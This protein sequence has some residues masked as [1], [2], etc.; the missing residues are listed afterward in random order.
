MP[1]EAG[2]QAHFVIAAD[3]QDAQIK[4]DQALAVDLGLG[5]VYELHG[6]QPQQHLLIG[7]GAMLQTNA[8]ESGAFNVAHHGDLL[9]GGEVKGYLSGNGAGA[10][11]HVFAAQQWVEVDAVAKV[12]FYAL[13]GVSRAARDGGCGARGVG[14]AK[15]QVAS[16]GVAHHLGCFPGGGGDGWQSHSGGRGVQAE[17]CRCS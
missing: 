12:N 11:L 13:A 4:A 14:A 8:G 15:H 5:R 16:V 6:W 17:C 3:G 1:L 9:R 10:D 2:D 7:Y